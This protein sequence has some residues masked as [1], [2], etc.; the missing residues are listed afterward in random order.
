MKTMDKVQN[1]LNYILAI[2]IMLLGF[3]FM[4]QEVPVMAA[5]WIGGFVVDLILNIIKYT[6]NKESG[7]QLRRR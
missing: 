1:I 7:F 5:I 4:C 6:Y 3:I 2:S